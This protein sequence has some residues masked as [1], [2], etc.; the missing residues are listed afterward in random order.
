M[1]DFSYF[2]F[3]KITMSIL[4]RKTFHINLKINLHMPTKNLAGILIEIELNLEVNLGRKLVN[5][6]TI[7]SSIYD[8]R[9]ALY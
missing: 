3:F 2:I 4:E 1:N 9:M 8:H 7:L 6:F 5:N